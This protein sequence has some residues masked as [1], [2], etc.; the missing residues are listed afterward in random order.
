MIKLEPDQ[1]KA[2][3]LLRNGSI[4]CGGTGSGKSIT[5]LA[6]YYEKECGYSMKEPR[7][8]I[9]E[10]KKLIIITTAMKRDKHEWEKELALMSLYAYKI[11]SWNN[12]KKYIDISNAFFIFDEDHV[13]GYGSWTKSFLKITKNNHWLILSATP[14]DCW[15]D[16]MPVFIANGYFRHKTD[17]CDQH[18]IWD[19]FASYRRVKGYKNEEALEYY[20][21]QILVDI[22][23][24]RKTIPHHIDIL[25]SYDK[26]KYT[27]VIKNRW[28]I[29]E[30]KPIENT[31]QLFYI[32]RKVANSSPSRIL[33]LDRIRKH[34]N[35]IIVFYNFD[36]ELEILK[37]YCLDNQ[38]IFSEWNGHVHQSIPNSIKWIYLVQYTAGSEAW[39]CTTTDTIVFYS[40]NYSYKV[41]V[42]SAG[43]IDRRNTKFKDLYYY[44]LKS[45]ASIDISIA[46]ALSKKKD[47]NEKDFY[48]KLGSQEK[49][50]L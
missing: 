4:L 3:Q 14:G 7:P 47:F 46:K 34:S 41:M 16:Y 2:V 5:A 32:M 17:F 10:P 11:D 23:Y 12:I 33:A 21:S 1:Q 29:Y 44:H 38:L 20:R 40:Q 26:E 37:K 6:Y 9:F 18:V 28:N 45:K 35:K 22:E 19:P 13:V 39:E 49:I 8:T 27:Q 36:Y 25:C 42:Q 43:R 15:M 31:S 30:D 50:M 24:I 48:N